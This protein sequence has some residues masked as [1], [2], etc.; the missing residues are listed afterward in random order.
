MSS[1]HI[2]FEQ[3]ENAGYVKGNQ[4]DIERIQRSSLA[5][6]I[7]LRVEGA[8]LTSAE[9]VPHDKSAFAH[10]ASIA[11][12][13]GRDPC[14]EL[15]CR[16]RRAEELAQ[17]AA[18][19]SD[20]VYTH[21]FLSDFTAHPE[22]LTEADLDE[23]RSVLVNDL[24][25]LLRLRPLIDAGRVV[26]ITP[27]ESWCPHCFKMKTS[28]LENF[29]P[30]MIAGLTSAG[31]YLRT[32]FLSEAKA[33]IEKRGKGCS[34]RIH[35]PEDL[36]EHGFHASDYSHM[37]P[38]MDSVPEVRAL[39][40]RGRTV[41]LTRRQLEK[42]GIHKNETAEILESVLFELVI[43]QSFGTSFLTERPI[44]VKIL[45]S[46]TS[47][48]QQEGRNSLIRRHLTTLV[49]FLDG[50]DSSDLL[51]LREREAES[52]IL[53]RQALNR[54][55][56]TATDLTTELTDRHARE[57]Y[58]DELEPSLARLDLKLRSAQRS[59]AKSARR[60]ATVWVGAITFGLFS[61]LLP[62]G[63]AAAAKILGLTKVVADL[64]ESILQA[65]PDEEPIR[66]EDMYFLWK[67]RQASR[68]R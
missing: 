40:M 63:L 39:L 51:D 12:G 66:N 28:Q 21:N 27:P 62:P 52:F 61:G 3:L 46:L 26:P 9:L 56:D 50:I 15:R 45:Q 8:A 35:A 48:S 65:R 33:T 20:K 31:E 68:S 36:L 59:L 2:L 29:D 67:V 30:R 49:P 64:G 14:V 44:H 16:M 41:P 60:K 37:P 47:D 11:L 53:F 57:L 22:S 25:V 42:F 55:I 23:M 17:F 7:D 24:E 13:G 58:G 4:V 1:P 32:R 5:E 19:Y 38:E 10:S 18:L 6:I 54:T 43:S 34:I